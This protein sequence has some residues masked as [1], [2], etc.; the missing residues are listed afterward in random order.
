MTPL[1][2]YLVEE[3]RAIDGLLARASGPGPA[4]PIDLAAYEELRARLLRHIAIEEKLVFPAARRAGGQAIAARTHRLRVEHA[5]ITTLLVA[6]PDAA[7]IGELRRALEPHDAAEEGPGGVY[8]ECESLLGD[9]W[10]D[11]LA[12]ARAYPPVKVARLPPS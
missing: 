3:H 11:L 6:P 7:L 10:V 9:A 1:R 12:Q 2:A 5:A 8:D 4:G